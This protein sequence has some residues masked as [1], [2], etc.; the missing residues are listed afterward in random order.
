VGR[1]TGE[2]ETGEG[3]GGDLGTMLQNAFFLGKQIGE[4]CPKG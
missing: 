1:G 2:R 3:G 4:G